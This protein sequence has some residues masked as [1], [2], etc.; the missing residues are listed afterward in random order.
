MATKVVEDMV[1]NVIMMLIINAARVGWNMD[2]VAR[3]VAAFRLII[4]TPISILIFWHNFCL[5]QVH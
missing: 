2:E 1:E 4:F 3:L 5:L